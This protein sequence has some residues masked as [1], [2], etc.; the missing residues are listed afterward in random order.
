MHWTTR[1]VSTLTMIGVGIVN[2]A[3]NGRTLAYNIDLP[4]VKSAPYKEA[5]VAYVSSPDFV[6]IPNNISDEDRTCLAQ[7]IYFEAKNQSIKG[8]IAVGIVTLRRVASSKFPDDICGVTRYTHFVTETG[9]PIKHKCHFSWYCDGK[10]D[11]PVEMR[12][13]QEAQN[14]ANAL[15]S[16]E[17]GIIDFTGG[18]DHYHADYIEPPEWTNQMVRV[19]QIQNHIFYTTSL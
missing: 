4:A 8:Q 5:P 12:A 11:T 3:D 19:A 13:W 14:I 9:F 2:F 16:K 10:P 6:P 7:N 1:F 15:L 18:A 17:S